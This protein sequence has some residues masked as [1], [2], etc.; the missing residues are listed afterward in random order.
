MT[1]VV[2]E[3]ET[4]RMDPE[5]AEDL[6]LA[7]RVAGG[8][9]SALK[10]LYERHADPLFAFVCHSLDGARSEAEE[11]WQDTLE[12]GI[13]TLPAYQ[14]QSRFFSWLCG[15][16]RHK[17]ADH[18]RRQNR[19]RQHVCLMPPEDLT[20]LLDEGPL[21]DEVV[22]RRATC[23]RVVE[24]LGLL[25]LDYRTALVARYAEG[26]SVEEIARLLDK[27]YKATESVLSRAKEAFRA[28]LAGRSEMEL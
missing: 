6:A 5:T 16:A 11:V 18:W 27:S 24:I 15:I 2:Q 13:R 28:A 1:A 17:L 21:P 25:P 3:L 7:Q 4:L 19:S 9:E 26:H 20:R 23:L 22:G 12:A 10:A 14:G 8:D